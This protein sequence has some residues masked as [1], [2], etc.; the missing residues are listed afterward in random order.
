MGYYAALAAF[1]IVA[2]LNPT[3][4]SVIGTLGLGGLGIGANYEK[5]RTAVGAFLKDRGALN[6]LVVEARSRVLRCQD[7]DD[8][9]LDRVEAFLDKAFEALRPA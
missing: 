1:G 3:V 5:A 8:E 7:D 2:N 4:G 9:C 6:L